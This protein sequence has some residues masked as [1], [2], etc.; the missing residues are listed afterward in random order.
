MKLCLKEKCLLYVLCHLKHQC[1]QDNRPRRAKLCYVGK[2]VK[3]WVRGGF[4]QLD[5]M[6]HALKTGRCFGDRNLP[7]SSAEH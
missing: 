1:F 2:D 7:L 3:P 5:V 4:L 6:L